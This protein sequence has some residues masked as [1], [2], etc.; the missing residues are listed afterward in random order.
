MVL[1]LKS[2]PYPITIVLLICSRGS[3]DIGYASLS[4]Q[5]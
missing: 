3:Q 4:V 1:T 2:V 5:P